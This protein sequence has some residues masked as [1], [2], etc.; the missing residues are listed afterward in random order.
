MK[1]YRK[2]L[3][4]LE[5]LKR[6]CIRLTY[7]KKQTSESDLLP[8]FGSGK[9]S[10]K[11]KN[12]DDGTSLGA[13]SGIVGTAMGL[14]NGA[15]PMQT[16]LSLAGPVLKSLGKGRPKRILGTIAKDLLVAYAMGK[17]VQLAVKGVKW[18]LKKRK[19]KQNEEKAIAIVQKIKA[20][21]AAN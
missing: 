13:M 20:A 18:Y 9:S 5:E 10:K 12:S 1:L 6:E 2:K 17:G 16:A 11:K 3:N 8:S 4:S 21:Q 14:L 19:A 15:S 7:E